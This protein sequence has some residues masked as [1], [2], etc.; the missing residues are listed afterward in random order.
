MATVSK[1]NDMLP[2]RVYEKINHVYDQSIS[3]AGGNLDRL[4]NIKRVNNMLKGI[5][6]L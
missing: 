4:K 5:G 1:G 6:V 3:D 2:I